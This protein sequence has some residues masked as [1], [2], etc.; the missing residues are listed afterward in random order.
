MVPELGLPTHSTRARGLALQLEHR[1]YR[2]LMPDGVR[3]DTT[4]RYPIFDLSA[5]R[6]LRAIVHAFSASGQ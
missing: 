2:R 1:R 4:L 5:L 6:A 3:S